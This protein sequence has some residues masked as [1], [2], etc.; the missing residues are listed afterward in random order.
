[1]SVNAEWTTVT[2]SDGVTLPVYRAEP[3]GEVK[4][5]VVVVQEIFG[6]NAHIRS[7]CERFAEEGYRA[8][9]PQVFERQAPGFERDYTGDAV[10][11]GREILGELDFDQAARDIQAAGRLLGKQKFG[12]V[13]FCMGGSLAY[14]AAMTIPDVGAAV[15][16]YGRH[17]PDLAVDDPQCPTLLHFGEQDGTIPMDRV[18]LARQRQPDLPLYTYPAG[19]GFNCDARAD[20]D[21]ESSRLA[22]QRTMV[23]LDENLAGI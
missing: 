10:V 15:A 23:F 17:V 13:G 19:H 4:G 16:Y 11:E 20:Y 3:T 7:V 22:W 12:V 18:E 1:M 6:V 14:K 8:A 21:P 9:A 5:N 2:A